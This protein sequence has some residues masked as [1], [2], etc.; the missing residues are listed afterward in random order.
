MC[1]CVSV[2]KFAYILVSF[3]LKSS[4]DAFNLLG[5]L[6]NTASVRC[7][8]VK[9]LLKYT[10]YL[11]YYGPKIDRINLDGILKFKTY[12]M[13]LCLPVCMSAE[14][15][16]VSSS[17]FFCQSLWDFAEHKCDYH[18]GYVPKTTCHWDWAPNGATIW[19][20]IQPQL[21]FITQ[22]SVV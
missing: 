10:I 14:F 11:C 4:A 3:K 21:R 15:L 12:P 13:T 17:S 18:A 16:F 20:E 1:A 9:A 6:K 8:G 19:H 22:H 7:V 2:S 5:D